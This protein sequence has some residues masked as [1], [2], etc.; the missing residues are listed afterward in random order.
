MDTLYKPILVRLVFNEH[1]QQRNPFRFCQSEEQ[2]MST[3]KRHGELQLGAPAP[4]YK[5][6]AYKV[7]TVG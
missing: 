7:M 2:E 1:F 4:S 3:E 6:I 5:S